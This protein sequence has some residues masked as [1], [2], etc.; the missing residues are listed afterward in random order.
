M[1]EKTVRGMTGFSLICITI[2]IAARNYKI[3]H[4][5][6][7]ICI[8]IAPDKTSVFD[9][10]LLYHFY[11]WSTPSLSTVRSNQRGRLAR[12][13]FDVFRYPAYKLSLSWCDSDRIE[14]IRSL[15]PSF[16]ITQYLLDD[17]GCAISNHRPLV[18][19]CND[20]VSNSFL[21][22]LQQSLYS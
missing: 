15:M 12:L 11:H 17:W 21:Y 13:C 10:C 7:E 1:S 16:I 3:S 22:K 4:S 14:D 19:P 8:W 20:R 9:L 6:R 2:V 18:L 5:R